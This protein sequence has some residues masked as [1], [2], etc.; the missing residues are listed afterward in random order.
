M[1][2][3]LRAAAVSLAVT[4]LVLT[5]PTATA[6]ELDSRITGLQVENAQISVGFST[7]VG[8]IDLA[9][10]ELTIDGQPVE[11][12]VAPV[13]ESDVDR[14]VVLLMDTSNSMRGEPIT[15]AK[16]AALDFIAGVPDEVLIGLVSFNRGA[17]L[18]QAPTLDHAAVAEA[19]DSL[20]LRRQTTLYDGVVLAAETA[21]GDGFRSV[22]LLS[23]GR[24]TGGAATLEDAV[25]AVTDSR[26]AFDAVALGRADT[27]ALA[28]LVNAGNG[29]LIPAEQASQLGAIFAEQAEAVSNEIII[30][31]PL[32]ATAP[33]GAAT[34]GVTAQSAG[35]TV[36]AS[37]VYS[38]A[39]SASATPPAGGDDGEGAAQAAPPAFL[40]TGWFIPVAI[41]GLFLG[42]LG[43]LLVA[44]GPLGRRRDEVT[45]RLSVYTLTSRGATEVER[46]QTAK[47]GAVATQALNMADQVVRTQGIEQ[48]LDTKLSA[49]DV[50]MT[51]AEWLL[52]HVGAAIG[53][54]LLLFLVSS[55]NLGWMLLGL[56]LG[57]LI[58]F[59]VLSYRTSKR[60]QK[61]TEQLPDT[62][63][64]MA[65]SL[66]AGYS[67]P[68][69]VDSVVREGQEPIAGEMNKALLEARLGVPI[70]E[71]LENIALRTQ[72]KDFA[73]IVMAIAI[74]RQVGGNL[75][76]ILRIVAETLRERAYIRRQIRSLSAEGRLSAII[77][78]AMPLFMLL[79][80]VLV[81]PEYITTLFTDPWGIAMIVAALILQL[82][83]WLWM[84]RLVNF[85]V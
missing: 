70:E 53:G 45:K 24:D 46:K 58:P 69:A 67:M 1:I 56:G 80:M 48:S 27:E 61:F 75:S 25:A 12:E 68:Q 17:T 77:I 50:P 59:L 39:E 43:L 18:E 8:A 37:A 34:I 85:E 2:G 40:F 16:A 42:L 73:W 81:R 78:A 60:Q 7:T 23:D 10:V 22:L 19:V 55:F 11:A 28:Q 38:L 66:S 5:V 83:G 30:T 29:T 44:F 76:E 52:L 64:L 32:P 20:P 33:T 72:S 47:S 6:Q 35:T 3:T 62:L 71:A 13:A 74:Q 79:Y 63:V 4:L 41:I 26:V 57:T 15:S 31:G 21:G 9:S 54:G 65:G 49:A 36:S 82:V 51:P 14:T 84:R